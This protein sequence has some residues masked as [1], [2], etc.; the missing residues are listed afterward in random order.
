M[1]YAIRICILFFPLSDNSIAIVP[2]VL[3]IVKKE[4]HAAARKRQG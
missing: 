2:S 1:K 3:I 4:N